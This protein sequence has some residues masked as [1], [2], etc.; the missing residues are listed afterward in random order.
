MGTLLTGNICLSKIDKNKIY[1]SEKT[2]ELYLGV[3]LW[4]NDQ[5]D[6]YGN[7]ASLVV[8]AT[9]EERE[10]KAKAVYLAN[11]KP[12]P[13]SEPVPATKEDCDDLPF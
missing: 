13:K 5:P 7:T 8:T 11:F 6:Q 1:K 3:S 12:L 2:G 9:K 4:L 10:A